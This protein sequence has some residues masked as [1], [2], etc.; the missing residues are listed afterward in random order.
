MASNIAYKALLEDAK[1]REEMIRKYLIH[2]PEKQIEM[3]L[4]KG[5]EKVVDDY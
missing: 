3:D 2:S 5:Y 4:K 1:L